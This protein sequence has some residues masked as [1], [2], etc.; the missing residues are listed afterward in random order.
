MTLWHTHSYAPAAAR[1][2][3]RMC[4]AVAVALQPTSS[5]CSFR[6]AFV[7][8]FAFFG[9]ALELRCHFC[10]RFALYYSSIYFAYCIA[11]CFILYSLSLSP[12]LYFVYF[13]CTPFVVV[14][15][16]IVGTFVAAEESDKKNKES[17]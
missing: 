3:L 4:A 7:L 15:C 17:R 10:A 11:V 16:P 5:G 8:A 13:F 1:S 12:A 9:V 14:K 6:F 2:L